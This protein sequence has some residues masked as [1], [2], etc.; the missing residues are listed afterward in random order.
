MEAFFASLALVALSELGDKTML[1]VLALA[2]QGS[3]KQVFGG[4]FL[5]IL[6]LFGGAVLLGEAAVELLPRQ[7]IAYGSGI[8][9][10]AI[11]IYGLV[12]FLRRKEEHSI[13]RKPAGNLFWSAFGIFAVAELGDKTQLATVGLTV[14]FNSPWAVFFGAV[15]GETLIVLL[16]ILLGKVVAR[17][18][19]TR[20]INLIAC[21]IFIAV[22]AYIVVSV[23]FQFTIL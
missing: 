23:A 9:F 11:G 21:F 7:Y 1:V 5:A 3:A 20:L 15:A 2:G 4:T 19:P 14:K 16:A 22:G 13:E 8:L 12:V 6:L 17:Y 10:I 18:L